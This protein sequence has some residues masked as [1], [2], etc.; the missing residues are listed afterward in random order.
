VE[1]RSPV[2]NKFLNF[3]LVAFF[4]GTAPEPKEA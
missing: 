3:L 2:L 4:E 1:R